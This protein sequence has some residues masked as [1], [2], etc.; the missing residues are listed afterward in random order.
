MRRLQ[1]ERLQRQ[2][3]EV[4]KTARLKSG[5]RGLEARKALNTFEKKIS[6]SARLYSN[7]LSES[8]PCV[9][10]RYTWKKKYGSIAD[11]QYIV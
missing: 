8:F 11:S 5:S 7:L 9:E 2:F 10:F 4:E 3:F 6:E 1:H